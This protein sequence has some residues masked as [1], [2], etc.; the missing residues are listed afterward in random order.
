M[1]NALRFL[2]SGLLLMFVCVIAFAQASQT[3]GITGVVTDK[4]GAVVSGATVDIIS[5]ATGKSVRSVTT[6]DDGG[7]SVTLL[8]PGK[9]RVEVSASS[10]KKAAIAGVDVRITETTR[11]DVSLDG[12]GIRNR[13]RHNGTPAAGPARGRTE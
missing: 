2:A 8:P 10:F 1:Q 13:A 5:D 11:Q 7:F 3:G 6:G 9:Y 4:N 12:G